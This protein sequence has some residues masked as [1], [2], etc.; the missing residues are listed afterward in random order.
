MIGTGIYDLTTTVGPARYM[1]TKSDWPRDR[2]FQR[3]YV[4]GH[5][6][7]THVPSHKAFTDDIRAWVLSRLGEE[8]ARYVKTLL[9]LSRGLVVL[10]R[11]LLVPQ[12]QE[13][14]LLAPG[15]DPLK[16]F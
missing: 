6:A 2:V 7:Y 8:D 13:H 11:G 12:A 10:G 1:V 9:W 14:L 4:G 3:Q 15:Y 16:M 5:M